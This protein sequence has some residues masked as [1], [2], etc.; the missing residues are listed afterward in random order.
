[1]SIPQGLARISTSTHLA[2]ERTSP[3]TRKQVPPIRSF[4]SPQ[5]TISKPHQTK[6]LMAPTILSSPA[7]WL[8]SRVSTSSA[9][10]SSLL[11]LEA[12]IRARQGRRLMSTR[13]QGGG[14]GR[15]GW[16]SLTLRDKRMLGIASDVCKVSLDFSNKTVEALSS[17]LI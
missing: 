11:A 16:H 1:M 9:T 2:Q 7:D 3:S 17:S 15:L 8:A 6:S 5:P 10:T 13:A 14:M 4:N 12:S